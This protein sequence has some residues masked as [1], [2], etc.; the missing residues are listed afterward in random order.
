MIVK[1]IDNKDYWGI[2]T[3]YPELGGTEQEDI[4]VAHSRKRGRKDDARFTKKEKMGVGIN[5]WN[6]DGKLFTKLLG[7]LKG[8]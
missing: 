8:Y 1:T 3:D 2:R 7:R 5:G 6:E 4:Q